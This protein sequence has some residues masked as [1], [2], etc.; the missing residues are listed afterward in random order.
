MLNKRV[1]SN[2]NMNK[3]DS[4]M[5]YLHKSGIKYSVF[6]YPEDLKKEQFK[7]IVSWY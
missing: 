5:R 4:L 2:S 7:A 6:Y 1:F 3:I